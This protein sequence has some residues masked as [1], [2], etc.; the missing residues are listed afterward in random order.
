MTQNARELGFDEARLG[1]VKQAIEADLAAGRGHGAAL[2]VARRGRIALDL[3]L[4]HADLAAGRR[5]ERDDVFVTMSSGKQFTTALALAF[6]ERGLLQLHRP[7]A[8]VLPGFGALGKERVNLWHLLTQTS[9]LPAA[10]P[11]VPPEV[12][13]SIERMTEY[14]SGCALE[15]LPGERVSYSIALAHVT[16]AA[17]CL[18]V[19]GRGRR[20]AQLLDDELFRPLRM[21]HTALGPRD[22]L[23]KRLCPVRAA[24]S[25]PGLFDPAALEGIGQLLQ[26]PG[27]EI[28]AGGFLTTVGDL[29]RFAEMLRRGGELDGARV[30]SPAMLEFA[31]RNQTGELPNQ[32]W[33]YTVGLRGWTPFPAYLGLGFFLRGEKLTPGPWGALN[34]PNTFGGIGAGSTAFWVDP[35]R[36]LSFAFLSTGLLEDSHHLERVARLSDLVVAAL[37]DGA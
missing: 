3:V 34:S 20:Y 37:V 23:L 15:C 4:G 26:I 21:R 6:V 16:M 36:E 18:R 1:R 24:Y 9:G 12:L 29:H 28:P 13:T 7:V 14:V 2:V 27:C 8:E 30:L 19:D 10:I 22:D 5:L 31:S 11:A 33:N 25:G 35:A 32:L 17:M